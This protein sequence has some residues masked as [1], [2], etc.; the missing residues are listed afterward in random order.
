MKI[1][2]NTLH[3]ERAS[4]MFYRQGFS[5]SSQFKINDWGN[6]GEYDVAL[7]MTY[8]E[9]MEQ[10]AEA[11]KRHPLL[12]TGVCDP[13]SRS[14]IEGH[15]KYIDFFIV[16][17]I[18][19]I[20]FWTDFGKPI[21]LYAEY[22]DC[23]E[24][25]KIHAPKDK[26][27]LGYH[28]NLVHLAGMFPRLTGAI[29]KLA[30]KY[31]LELW[32]V[33]NIAGS[34][35]ASLG[36]PAGVNIRHIQWHEQ[37]YREE[38]VNVDIGLVPA[39]MPLYAPRKNKKRLEVFSKYYLEAEDD[40]L[41]RFKMPTN[42]GR[43]IVFARLGIPVVADFTPSALQL[44]GHGENGMLAV[45]SGAWYNALE[46]LI[47]DH[48]LRG[49]MAGALREKVNRL[50]DYDHQNSRLLEFIEQE[51]K[52]NLRRTPVFDGIAQEACCKE[53]RRNAIRAYL[54]KRYIAPIKNRLSKLLG[55]R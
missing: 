54:K 6:Y 22:F 1:V 32:V 25:F 46:E 12:R 33:Y 23:G 20:D 7:F 39:L 50:Y 13:R 45:S 36:L 44:I 30:G 41:L 31:D 53:M 14:L 43:I 18:E 5:R 40:Y 17:S 9:D 21:C 15:L 4:S 34:G 47:L 38:L 52:G 55:G 37:V 28:G 27:I 16:D 3:L 48:K 11:K 8:A 29:E 2:F 26:I 24:N 49:E 10:M 19:M 42:P 35:K 51:L